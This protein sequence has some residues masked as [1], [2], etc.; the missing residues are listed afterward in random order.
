MSTSEW[1][2]QLP[3]DLP[4]QQLRALTDIIE[5]SEKAAHAKMLPASVDER[6]YLSEGINKPLLSV[7]KKR[8]IPGVD[9]PVSP[10]EELLTF[11]GTTEGAATDTGPRKS[12]YD[13]EDGVYPGVTTSIKPYT[14]QSTGNKMFLLETVGTGGPAK[15]ISYRKYLPLS[16]KGVGITERTLKVFGVKPVGTNEDGSPKYAFKPSEIVN[17]PCDMKLLGEEFNGQRRMKLDAVFAPKATGTNGDG[18]FPI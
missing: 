16:G 5:A 3:I 6:R 18:G 1:L 9:E 7:E 12:R 10:D 13:F 14:A 8:M 2:A 17:K 15:G 4:R 11:D